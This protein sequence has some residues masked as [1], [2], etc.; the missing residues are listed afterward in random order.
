MVIRRLEKT[1]NRSE[2]ASGDDHLDRFFRQQ[3]RQAQDRHFSTTYIA[4]ADGVIKGFATV[5]SSELAPTR[6]SE[7][8]RKKLPHGFL[9]VLRLARMAVATAYQRTGIGKL[10]LTH[11]FELAREQAER[12]GCVGVVVDAKPD[13]VS[14]YRPFGF[15]DIDLV[16]GELPSEEEPKPM[17]LEIG[18]IPHR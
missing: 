5:V 13:A 11:V 9:P 10:L 1:D 15:E 4:E 17:F 14:F 12:S 6:L 18:M 16:E 2:F 7:H 8:A 3:A